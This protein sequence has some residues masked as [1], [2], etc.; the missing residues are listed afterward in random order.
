MA[1]LA[2]VIKKYGSMEAF[3]AANPNNP[4]P[5]APNTFSSATQFAAST[6]TPAVTQNTKSVAPTYS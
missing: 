6:A 1:T 4:Q 5:T 2:D 3:K